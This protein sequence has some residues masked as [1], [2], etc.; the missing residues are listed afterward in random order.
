MC[1]SRKGKSEIV[2]A[3]D[4]FLYVKIPS[5]STKMKKKSIGKQIQFGVGCKSNQVYIPSQQTTQKKNFQ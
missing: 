4:T 5:N 1:L 2:S 3:H